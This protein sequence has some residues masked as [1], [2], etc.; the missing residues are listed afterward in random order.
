[1]DG[2]VIDLPSFRYFIWIVRKH[3]NSIVTNSDKLRCVINN[4]M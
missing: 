4:I 2:E 1:M 3:N